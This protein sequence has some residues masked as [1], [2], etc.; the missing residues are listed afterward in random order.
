MIL[1]LAPTDTI[2]TEVSEFEEP[3]FGSANLLPWLRL[4][5]KK[6]NSTTESDFFKRKST[7]KLTGK[8][9]TGCLHCWTYSAIE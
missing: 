9:P 6:K 7:N 4:K 8:I 5:K 3:T 2:D 1:K